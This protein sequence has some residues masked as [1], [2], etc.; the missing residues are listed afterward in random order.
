[1]NPQMLIR[2]HMELEC[3]AVNNDGDLIPIPCENPDHISRLYIARHSDGYSLFFRYDVPESTRAQLRQFSVETLF[4]DNETVKA[5]LAR[6][7]PCE[8]IFAGKSYSYPRPEAVPHP[9]PEMIYL[10]DGNLCGI[11]VNGE[12]VSMCSSS[13]ENA[14]AGE[15]WVRTEHDFR[16]KGYAKRVTL[17]WALRLWEQGKIPFY[18]HRI[19]NL[20]SEVV[21]KAVGF[22]WYIDDVG[23][24]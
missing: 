21:A 1:M 9:D 15:A 20:A 8:D 14:K 5:I 13:R 22:E 4:H 16:G 19:D 17:A 18:S 7:A 12:L 3:I 11:V 23:Y 2:L 10:P 24:M 6:E